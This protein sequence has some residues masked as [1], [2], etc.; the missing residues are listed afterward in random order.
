MSSPLRFQ[1]IC[2]GGSPWTSHFMLTSSSW[3]IAVWVAKKALF[4]KLGG[5]VNSK[6]KNKDLRPLLGWLI[7]SALKR[8]KRMCKCQNKCL[9]FLNFLLNVVDSS[10][11]SSKNCTFL[12]NTSAHCVLVFYFSLFSILVLYVYVSIISLPSTLIVMSLLFPEEPMPF[13]AWHK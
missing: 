8:I 9:F 13:F 10:R 1:L 4:K 5:T 3:M 6:K 12:L 2:K 11:A 7:H